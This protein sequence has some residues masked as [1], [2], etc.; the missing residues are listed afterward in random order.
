MFDEKFFSVKAKGVMQLA[1]KEARRLNHEYIGTG[2]ILLGLLKLTRRNGRKVS[3]ILSKSGVNYRKI[4]SEV[5]NLVASG[6]EPVTKSELSK[7]PRAKKV[8]E[9]ALE[10]AVSLNKTK[11][12]TDDL[13]IGLLRVKEGIACLTLNKFGIELEKVQAEL[14]GLKVPSLLIK[15]EVLKHKDSMERSI[16]ASISPSSKQSMQKGEE[17]PVKCK[18][19][20]FDLSSQDYISAADMITKFLSDGKEVT[21]VAQSLSGQSIFFITIFYRD[22]E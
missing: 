17:K 14:K 3:K 13:F 21:Q 5:K 11:V 4:Y 22:K 18:I 10:S 2:H 20:K 7:T 6:K 9:Y 15:E 12:E 16:E 19:F 8:I 1:E